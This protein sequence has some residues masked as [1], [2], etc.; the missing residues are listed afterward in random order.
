VNGFKELISDRYPTK[1]SPVVCKD[2][3]EKLVETRSVRLESSEKIIFYEDISEKTGL[4][5]RLRNAQK[6]EAIGTLAGGV[7]HDLNNILSGIL[8]YPD[9]LL[10]DL[11]QDSPLRDPLL[12]IKKSGEKAATIVL[13]LL[14]LAR[15]G[16]MVKEV[17]NV[18]EIISEY[19]KS[20]E[21]ERLSLYHR[22]VK[23]LTRFDAHLL[24]ILGSP[25]HLSKV[26][27]NLVFNAAEAMPAGGEVHISTQ[28]LYV[29]RSGAENDLFSE[30]EYVV[31]RVT[32]Q[33][34]GISQK[35]VER[36][37][38]PFYTTKVMGRSGTGLGMSV[39]W[40][41]VEDHD[42]FINI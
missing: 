4:E 33:G 3:S 2:G 15:R 38:E 9:L 27:M 35:E 23:F 19:L 25:V 10:M 6:M 11:P 12:T 39:V 16:V 26:I 42:G 30:G 31:V 1:T 36:I 8:S 17:T 20:P 22:G 21:H 34:I 28:N 5:M 18:N 37:F 40:G 13:D 24:N 32:D 14:T 41:T 7:A 29:D